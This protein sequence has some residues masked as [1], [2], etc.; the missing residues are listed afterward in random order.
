MSSGSCSSN[1]SSS[2]GRDSC[3]SARLMASSS[4]GP[5][6]LIL[7]SP[8]TPPPPPPPSSA[9]PTTSTNHPLGSG[10]PGACCCDGS[11]PLVPDPLT[12]NALFIASTL[13]NWLLSNRPLST[14]SLRS[15]YL[16]LPIR[17][18]LGGRF[19]LLRRCRHV[20]RPAAVEWRSI[21]AGNNIA[22]DRRRPRPRPQSLPS[23]PLSPATSAAAARRLGPPSPGGGRRC[24]RRCCRSPTAAT[25]FLPDPRSI[26]ILRSCCKFFFPWQTRLFRRPFAFEIITSP[27]IREYKEREVNPLLS[28]GRRYYFLAAAATD[29]HQSPRI[30][31]STLG[32]RVDP[33]SN[34]FSSPRSDR[35]R[36]ERAPNQSIMKLLFIAARNID[37]VVAVNSRPIAACGRWQSRLSLSPV[38]MQHQ[39]RRGLSLA[40]SRV[41]VTH[42][43]G[44]RTQGLLTDDYIGNLRQKKQRRAVTDRVAEE[45]QW[46]RVLYSRLPEGMHH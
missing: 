14:F 30:D 7:S 13:L 3:G 22:G 46:P 18:R 16:R 44:Q 41:F 15:T 9:P 31:Q 38:F 27:T 45:K 21:G 29:Y 6:P 36:R 35:V 42:T 32:R 37:S 19:F 10:T 40:G 2:S 28:A 34:V 20:A 4:S 43:H 11:R 39:E 5:A 12:G 25:T 17:V 24:C 8:R 23:L 1:S 33:M 26:I